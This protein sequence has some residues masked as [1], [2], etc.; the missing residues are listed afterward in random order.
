MSIK[1]MHYE[2]EQE[3]DK[4]SS[5]DRPDILPAQK[6]SYLNKAIHIWCKARYGIHQDRGFETDQE[7][8]SN[9]ANLHIKSPELQP[10]IVPIL[11]NGIYE[12]ELST[13]NN[14]TYQYL[15]LTRIR[16]EIKDDTCTKTTDNLKP[17]QTD[18]TF[19]TFTKPSLKWGRVPV[20]FGKSSQTSTEQSVYLETDGFTVEKVY[21]DYIKTPNTVFSDGYTHING[22]L[23]DSGTLFDINSVNCDIDESFHHEIVSLAV[24]E[25]R[26]DLSDIQGTQLKKLRTQLDF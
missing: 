14:L 13:T 19:N 15:F 4:L 24:E 7:R 26:S 8:I 5:E 23:T 1:E 20:R 6:D 9:L 3:L 21:L 18:D 10:A 12:V 11:T 17:H 16:A 2:F 22:T 25:V